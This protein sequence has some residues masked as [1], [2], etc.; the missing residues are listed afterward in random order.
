[1]PPTLYDSTLRECLRGSMPASCLHT[2][3]DECGEHGFWCVKVYLK[4]LRLD[5]HSINY[6]CCPASIT[7]WWWNRLSPGPSQSPP[8][9]YGAHYLTSI[10][11]KSEPYKMS[12]AP[13]WFRNR[14]RARVLDRRRCRK[15][16]HAP[17]PSRALPPGSRADGAP[18]TPART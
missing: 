8:Q 6:K 1:M 9:W 12:R 5:Q 4:I 3:V 15:V 13:T 17:E 7:T 11:S 14:S 18:A 16:G 2:Y 10:V